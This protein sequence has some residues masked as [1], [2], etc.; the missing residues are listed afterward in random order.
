MNIPETLLQQWWSEAITDAKQGTKAAFAQ[1]AA[2]WV[3]SQPVSME[4]V[5]WTTKGQIAS[6]EHGFNHYIQG[7]VPR[8]V[9]PN[10]DD[11]ALY[12]ATQ[13]AQ[14]R[15]Q[16][17]EE[18]RARLNLIV[19]KARAEQEAHE[20]QA[21]RERDEYHEVADDLA[22]Q[23]A[24]ITGEDIGEHSSANNPWHNAMLAADDFIAGQLKELL[25][26]KSEKQR[27]S[28]L[29]K[30]NAV[31]L[32]ACKAALSDD[33]PYIEKCRAAIAEVKP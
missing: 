24:A 13:L 28:E 4:P 27:I 25:A 17:V 33:Q 5:A 7:R 19:D 31:L 2:E 8:F 3:L 23:I 18:E 11:V 32:E 9:Q 10:D 20:D 26:G 30:S 16:G 15:L 6:M 22:A 21:L 14:A 1:R 29:E 12:T